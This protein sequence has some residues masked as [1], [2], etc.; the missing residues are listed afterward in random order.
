V[1]LEAL[2]LTSSQGHCQGCQVSK[3][4]YIGKSADQEATY[5]SAENPATSCWDLAL[6][7]E[8]MK[9]SKLPYTV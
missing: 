8:E 3:T 1:I 5:G 4:S 7:S 6:E 2:S 9:I